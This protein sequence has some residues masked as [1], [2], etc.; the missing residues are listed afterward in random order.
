MEIYGTEGDLFVTE[1]PE[2]L[3]YKK[4]DLSGAFEPVQDWTEKIPNHDATGDFMR[5]FADAVR[6]RRQPIL[7]GGD[8]LKALELV[9]EAIRIAKPIPLTL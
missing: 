3:E 8:G 5:D 9:F 4:T 2:K 7:N 6:E 1:H